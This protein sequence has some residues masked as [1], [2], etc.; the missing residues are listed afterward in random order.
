M[1]KAGKLFLA[2]TGRVLILGFGI[3]IVMGIGWMVRNFPYLQGFGETALYEEISKTFICDEYEGILYPILIWFAR[4]IAK[5]FPIPYHCIMYGV[6][7]GCGFGAGCFLLRC[8]GM[9][10]K[11]WRI[12]GSLA[13]L[14]FPMSMQ[15][16]LA[17]LPDSFVASAL[18]L[19]L[20]LALR[21]VKGEKVFGAREFA[22]VSGCWVVL[23]LLRPEYLYLGAV[24]VILLF[25]YG[26]GKSWKQ[27]KSA[28][29][30]CGILICAFAGM[31]VGVTSLTQTDGYYGRAHK[32]RNL[33]MASR[34]GWPYANKD[35]EEWPEE[36]KAY[37]SHEEAMQIAFYADHVERMLGRT[38]EAQVGEVRAEKLLGEMALIGWQRHKNAIL[39]DTAWDVVG[40][41][42]SPL[43]VQ[44]QLTGKAYDSYSGRNYD[45]MR[46]QAP[47]LSEYYLNFGSFWFGTGLILAAFLWLVHW[48]GEKCSF[49]KPG[50]VLVLF[51]WMVTVAGIVVW[52]SLQG[53][54]MM[55]YKKSLGVILLWL[56]WMLI[57]GYK[58]CE[59]GAK[60]RGD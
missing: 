42:F 43:V 33:A 47:Q 24:P 38:L 29:L 59:K 11:L 53:A 45:V 19:E 26:A 30:F 41:T 55:D 50:G 21:M 27:N 9:K 8:A 22:K 39:H 15:C 14:A 7:L 18:M 44:R 17:V 49:W 37:F 5:I 31:I 52:Y 60:S 10:S 40:Y 58:A 4:G 3:W 35:Y 16:H 54:G 25:C 48:C 46:Q 36:I 34:C 23:A 1:Q 32:S 57:A 6:Q 12:G 28:I 20:A 2:I 56:V 13:L 51:G